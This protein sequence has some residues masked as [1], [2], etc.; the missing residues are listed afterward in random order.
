MLQSLDAEER[1]SSCPT[2]LYANFGHVKSGCKVGCNN[3]TISMVLVARVS[4]LAP[5]LNTA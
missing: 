3:P 4:T 2:F 1:V 5:Q